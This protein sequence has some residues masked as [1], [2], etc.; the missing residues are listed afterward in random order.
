VL[1]GAQGRGEVAGVARVEPDGQ[2]QVVSLGAHGELVE[3]VAEE[4]TLT[5][6]VPTVAGVGIGPDAVA[7]APL[8]PGVLTGLLARSSKLGVFAENR[9]L[10]KGPVENIL[11]HKEVVHVL[12]FTDD[13]KQLI[14]MKKSPGAVSGISM[15]RIKIMDREA[16]E[17]VKGSE[18]LHYRESRDKFIFWAPIFSGGFYGE[19]DL[20]HAKGPNKDKIIG[21]AKT[22]FTTNVFNE[23]LK[24][25]FKTSIIMPVFFLIPMWIIVLVFVNGIFSDEYSQYSNL[26]KGIRIQ[27][28]HETLTTDASKVETLCAKYAPEKETAFAALNRALLKEGLIIEIDNN[29]VCKE[30]INITHVT[31]IT[32]SPIITSPRVLI[33]SGKSSEATILETHLCF[34]EDRALRSLLS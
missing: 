15:H 24:S 23:E 10:L 12:V 28:L 16:F 1:V 11:H 31:N 32:T 22:V 3:V 25:V 34:E 33:I 19:E 8:V 14:S 13:G 27:S 7:L 9:D 20:L 6:G 4:E 2:G 26:P 5:V 17:I 30:I 29:V 21:Y 18:T